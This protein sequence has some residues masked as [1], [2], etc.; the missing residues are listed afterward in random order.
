MPPVSSKTAWAEVEGDCPGSGKGRLYTL[1]ELEALPEPQFL[2]EEVLIEGTDAV[3]YGE[4][5]AHKSGTAI[6]M[7]VAIAGG[8]EWMGRKTRQGAVLFVAA[9][10]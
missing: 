8:R 9:L 7:A 2:I 5:E 6:S 10:I 3:L 1:E 4:S